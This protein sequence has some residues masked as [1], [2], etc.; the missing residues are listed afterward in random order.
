MEEAGENIAMCYGRAGWP[1]ATA[2]EVLGPAL[3]FGPR[4]VDEG[5]ARL[6]ELAAQDTSRWIEANVVLWLGRLEAMRGNFDAAREDI[7]RART[8]FMELALSSAL[9]D[10]CRRAAAVVA[11]AA[12]DPES[13]AR[14]LANAC[15]HLERLGETQVLATRGAELATVLYVAGRYEEATHWARIAGDRAGGDDLDAALAR[16]PVEAMLCA[17]EGRIDDAEL[18]ARAAVE[19][20]AKTDSPNRRAEALVALA[21]VLTLAGDTQ[22]AKEH[23][24]AALLLYE[25]KGN[26]AAAARVRA[27]YEEPSAGLLV[28][29]SLS[30]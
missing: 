10:T 30:T 2:V 18:R 22:N 21:E 11:L 1:L 6:R 28:P 12:G 29:D 15:E 8:G 19:L 26:T 27:K 17:R 13:A 7:E 9:A 23:V 5:I 3:E 25:Q 14:S 4:P 16:H 20:A 24:D